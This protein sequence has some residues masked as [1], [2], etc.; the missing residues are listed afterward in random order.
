MIC[1]VSELT[2]YLIGKLGLRHLNV[3]SPLAFFR[4]PFSAAVNYYERRIG[5]I[6]FVYAAHVTRTSWLFSGD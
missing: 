1:G 6:P 2:I 4:L 5:V 3:E